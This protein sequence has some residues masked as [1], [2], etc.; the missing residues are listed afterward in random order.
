MD[1]FL[2]ELEQASIRVKRRI[3]GN[4]TGN[5]KSSSL[6]NSYDFY[7]IRPYY[8]GDSIRNID[9]K[10]FGR[11]E[12]IYTRLFTEQKQMNITVLLDSSKSM[13]FNKS[14]KW[15]MAKMCAMGISYITLKENNILNMYSFN[16]EVD[17]NL[18]GM[19]SK[20]IFY[21][22]VKKINDI[23]PNKKTNFNRI[24]SSTSNNRG[25]IFIITDLLSDNIESFLKE[26]ANKYERVV[27]IHIMCDEELNPNFQGK[28]KLIDSET[29]EEIIQQ[30]GEKEIKAYKDNLNGFI[31]NC[32]NMCSRLG[33]RYIFS[34]R[35]SSPVNI[36]LDAIEVD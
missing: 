6:G 7:G 31:E 15:N 24:I 17:L 32:K 33:I 3:S 28:I 25:L 19:N 12:K 5:Y 34:P 27:V 30:L 20:N 9:W 2:K 11:T 36:I 16:E 35:Y 18:Q 29:G 26:S 22:I 1:K 23:N 21:E 13:D 10:A 14:N 4:L 8:K